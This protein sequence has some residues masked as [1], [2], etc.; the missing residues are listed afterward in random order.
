M[1]GVA[2]SQPSAD[3][4]THIPRSPEGEWVLVPREPTARMLAAAVM[5]AV[6]NDA[7]EADKLAAGAVLELLPPTGH[8][9][10]RTVIAEIARDYRAALSAAPLPSP[11]LDRLGGGISSVSQSAS[12]LHGAPSGS[13]IS[14]RWRKRPVVIDAVQVTAA[15]YNGRTW[16]GS[17]FSAGPDWLL[18]AI[19]AGVIAPDTPNHTDYAEWR[20]ATLE[21]V[22][23][24]TPGDWIIRGVKGE[25]YACKPD[26]FALTYEPADT[27]DRPTQVPGRPQD[28]ANQ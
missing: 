28:K 12:A 4:G 8:P 16:D 5:S 27:S 19:G 24:A 25:L 3:S 9:D 15:D 20:I 21:G 18:A 14:G 22:M 1:D 11:P 7:S 23:L 6:S 10:A 17:P 2:Q 13:E 26:V